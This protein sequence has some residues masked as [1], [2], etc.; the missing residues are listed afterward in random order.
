VAGATDRLISQYQNSFNFIALLDALI[1]NPMTAVLNGIVPLYALYDIDSMVGVQLDNIG[2]IIV[3]PRPNSFNNEDIYEEGIFTVGS[4]GGAGVYTPEI[5]STEGFGNSLNPLTGGRFGKSSSSGK[6][7]VD[8][9]YRLVLKGKIHANNTYGTVE[10]IEQF[11]KIMFGEYCWVYPH[12]GEVLVVFPYFLN[13]IAIEVVKQTLSVAKG[14][15]LTLAMQPSP[16]NGKVFGF[17][18]G[19]NTGGF[20]S[21]SDSTAGYAMIGIV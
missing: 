9:D 4:F 12:A 20:G 6:R 13:A 19:S 16:K 7:L 17:A 21:T 15:S 1:T 3:Q 10:Q 11:G 18:G 5:S 14:V 8:A 2:K